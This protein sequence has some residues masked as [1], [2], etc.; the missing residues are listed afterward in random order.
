MCARVAADYLL[1]T[2]KSLDLE[3]RNLATQTSLETE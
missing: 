1:L 3:G 2:D